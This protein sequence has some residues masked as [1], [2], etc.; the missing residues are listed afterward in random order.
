MA[1][2]GQNNTE[3]LVRQI[4]AL[5][6]ELDAIRS[7]LS[8]TLGDQSTAISDINAQ[9]NRTVSAF[10]RIRNAQNLTLDKQTKQLKETKS[11]ADVYKQIPD[12]LS[13]FKSRMMDTLSISQKLTAS[14]KAASGAKKAELTAFASTYNQTLSLATELSSLNKEDTLERGIQNNEI[15]KSLNLLQT[16]A[17]TY[18]LINGTENETFRNLQKQI[19]S[20]KNIVLESNSI[21]NVSKEIKDVYGEL[22]G[23]LDGLSKGFKKLAATIEVFFSSFKNVLGMS[24]MFAGELFDEFAQISKQIGGSVLQ[25]TGFKTQ[26]FAV[27]KLL[28]AEAGNAVIG[29]ADKLGNVNDVSTT[30]GFS[31]GAMS[32]RLGVSGEEAATLVN[33]FGNLQNLGSDIALN[34]MEATSQLA[35]ANGVAPGNVMKDI[36]ENTEFFASYSKD[37]GKNIAEAAIQ[38]RRLGV[39]LGT[40]A[41]ISD[42]LIDY[43]SSVQKEMEASVILGRNINLNEA[44]SL[45]MQGKNAEAMQSALEAAGGIDKFNKMEVYERRAVAD[46]LGVGVDKLQQMSANMERAATP[47]GKLEAKFES[48]SAVLTEMGTTVGGTILKGFGSVLMFTGQWSR[49]LTDTM[50]G[51]LGGIFSKIGQIGKAMLM[52]PAKGLNKIT[53]GALGRGFDKV[54]G[55]AGKF[56]GGGDATESISSKAGGKEAKTAAG[57]KKLAGGFTAMGEPG[58]GKGILNTALAGPALFLLSLGTPGMMAVGAF[59]MKAGKGLTSLVPGLVGFG[60]VPISAVGTLAATGAALLLLSLGTPGMMAVGAFGATAGKGLSKLAVGLLS[61]A[62]V[63]L[64]AVGTLAATA[65]AFILMIPGAIG[66]GLFG[67]AASS[68]AAGLNLLGPALVSF[69]ATA[70][71]VGWLGVAVIAALAASFVAFGYG[72]SLMTPAIQAIGV[73]ITSVITSIA[74]GISVIVGSITSMMTA[75][76][77]LLSIDSALGLLAMAGGFA[78]LSASLMAFAGASLL[79]LPGLLAVGGF[80]ALGGDVMLGGNSSG[81]EGGDGGLIEEI[82][83]LRADIKNL[84]VVVSLDSRQIYKGHVQNIK[85]N[86]QG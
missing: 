63:P 73:V 25:M 60:A 47:A 15:E 56:L 17:D 38:A 1:G 83:G 40:V 28:G 50:N 22:Y 64:L 7:G 37:G 26:V 33:Q 76:L 69:G 36:A 61:F 49:L 16:Q 58:V 81:G 4:R 80:M 23:D 8:S 30:L 13:G 85:N 44:R 42:S 24:L 21:A 52:L 3:E 70:G 48:A 57:Q 46:A 86:S 67:L 19:E 75:L 29:L 53:G 9:L 74:T 10:K 6:T 43:Q 66:M 27:S 84:A 72:L 62:A 59:G 55:F 41:D 39:D 51:P 78:A 12:S 82:R 11:L 31:V 54:K 77:P 5:H 34:T 35:M 65:G 68:A 20:L 32:S 45:A 2:Q 14:A 79:A 71:T 18:A